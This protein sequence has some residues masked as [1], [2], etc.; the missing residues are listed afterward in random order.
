M[1]IGFVVVV[2]LFFSIFLYI[3]RAYTNRIAGGALTDKFKAA[4][5]IANG[6][7]PE[8]W[9]RQIDRQT[10]RNGICQTT[11]DSSTSKGLLIQK[12]DELHKYFE[13]SPFVENPETRKI[14]LDAFSQARS[15]WLD[16]SWDDLVMDKKPAS[17]HD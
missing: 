14:L 13:V 11:T 8:Q 7:I 5:A 15:Q 6:A 17:T 10:V 9:I 16:S 4:E 1:Y 12:L 2:I 3:L